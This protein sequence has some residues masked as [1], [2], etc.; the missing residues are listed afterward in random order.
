MSHYLRKRASRYSHARYHPPVAASKARSLLI[1]GAYG[2]GKSTL[3]AELVEDLAEARVPCAAID[4]DWLSWCWTPDPRPHGV[5]DINLSNLR[6]VVETYRRVGV[7]RFVMAGTIK[8]RP[9]LDQLRGVLPEPLSVVRLSVPIDEIE[10]RLRA[11]ALTSRADDL[12][13]S[14][15]GPDAGAEIA[16]LTLSN[17]GPIADV[18]K[19]VLDWLGWS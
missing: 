7:E 2:T 10:R 1:T 15:S 17:E 4:F 16:D 13:V 3:A 19:R 9:E 11:D 12:E 18:A 5:N 6:A 14:R 8:T